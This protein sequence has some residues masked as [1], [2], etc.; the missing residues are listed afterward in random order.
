MRIITVLLAVLMGSGCGAG[1]G[2]RPLGAMFSSAV[3]VPAITALSPTSVP[4]NSVPFM[5]TVNG[6]N[7]GT[8]AIVFWNGIPQK[9][10][11]I[12]PQQL[13]VAITDADLTD[14]GLVHIFVRTGGQNSNT[15]DFVVTAQ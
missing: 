10:T 13:V 4:V 1:N 11:V 5:M 9:T 3:V 2:K 7:F 6:T 14:S 15:A 12:T 8:D